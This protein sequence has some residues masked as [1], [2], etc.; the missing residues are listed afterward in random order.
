MEDIAVAT[1][2]TVDKVLEKVENILKK[3][4]QAY[5]VI[6]LIGNIL[7]GSITN[8]L[9]P[10]IPAAASLYFSAVSNIEHGSIGT[11]IN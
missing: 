1:D 11:G 2:E 9:K 4:I 5:L 3:H 7:S 8:V 10:I 6:L